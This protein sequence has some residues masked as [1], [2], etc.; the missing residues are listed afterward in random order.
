MLWRKFQVHTRV[1]KTVVTFLTSLPTPLPLLVRSHPGGFLV[2]SGSHQAC[3]CHRA[4][5]CSSS[6]S[7]LCPGCL[8]GN[9]LPF[10]RTWL[11][12]LHKIHFNEPI[13]ATT[14]FST[15]QPYL[16]LPYRLLPSNVWGN[17]LNVLIVPP[18]HQLQLCLFTG[19]MNEWMKHTHDEVDSYMTVKWTEVISFSRD[20]G[21]RHYFSSWTARMQ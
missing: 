21:C 7:M 11:K 13:C 2:A 5:A 1:N 9:S 15:H 16:I 19:R 6:F 3:S 10:L 8:L 4:L 14:S 20:W 17:L 18:T 12:H